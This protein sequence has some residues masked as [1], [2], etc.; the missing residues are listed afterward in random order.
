MRCQ[1]LTGHRFEKHW[2]AETYKGNDDGPVMTAEGPADVVLM[3][4]LYCYVPE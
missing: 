2:M 4:M 3:K 1:E